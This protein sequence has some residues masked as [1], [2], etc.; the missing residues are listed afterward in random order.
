M[1]RWINR[2]DVQIYRVIDEWIITITLHVH[3]HV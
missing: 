2:V 3:V 1:N